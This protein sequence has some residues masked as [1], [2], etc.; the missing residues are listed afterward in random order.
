MNALERRKGLAAVAHENRAFDDVGLP[1]LADD[2]EARHASFADLGDV[3]QPDGRSFLTANGD[4]RDVAQAAD[5]TDAANGE[6]LLAERQTLPA[7]VLIRI[8]DRGVELRQRDAERAQAVGIDLDV[9]FLRQAAE[10]D[11]V[12]HELLQA[13]SLPHHA[14]AEDLADGVPRR[15]LCLQPIREGG[16]LEAVD[17][18][19]PRVLIVR[20]PVEIALH[21]RQA[22]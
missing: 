1:V 8:G 10:A 6:G 9:V 12:S 11:D 20:V 2:T 7:D 13:V 19:L 18:L 17:D 16:E 3:T 22:E 5:E 21:V 4:V 15:D 14:V